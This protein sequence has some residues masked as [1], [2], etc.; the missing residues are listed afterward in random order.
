MAKVLVC[1]ATGRIGAPLLHLLR[2]NGH[3]VFGL[4]RHKGSADALFAKGVTPVVG[5]IRE[6]GALGAQLD[7]FDVVFLASADAPDQAQAEMS[8]IV[9]LGSCGSPYVVKLSAQSAGLQPPVSFGV[10]HKRAE[11]ALVSSGLRCSIIR[12]TFFQQSL[13]LM[14]DDV[15]KR[16]GIVAPMGNGRTA[17]IDVRDVAAAAAVVL[18]DPAYAGKIYTLTG[19]EPVGLAQ[20]A[21][22]LSRQL[23]RNIRYTSPPTLISRLLMPMLTGLPRW[24]TSLIIDLM[25][26]IRNGAQET[27]TDSIRELTGQFPRNV[28][29]FL[30]EHIAA[31]KKSGATR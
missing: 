28:I 15:G 14:A 26:A 13:L 25:V 8:L 31:F 3:E 30:D 2:S 9:R 20:V 1:G 27:T 17:I 19:P 22:S 6:A 24:Q 12:P 23:G 21:T 11:D 29:A 10:A 18:N 5:N 16:G 4:T 7:G